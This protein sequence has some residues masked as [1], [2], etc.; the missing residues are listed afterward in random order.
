MAGSGLAESEARCE[1][2]LTWMVKMAEPFERS[3][4]TPSCSCL[5]MITPTTLA[6]EA[7]P[8]LTAWYALSSSALR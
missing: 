1:A 3:V 5:S 6:P 8:F 2:S 7:S 4:A